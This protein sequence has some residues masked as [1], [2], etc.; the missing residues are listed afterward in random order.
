MSSELFVFERERESR[1]K[2]VWR[3]HNSREDVDKSRDVRD[4]LLL[5]SSGYLWRPRA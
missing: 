5:F 2:S 4:S 1:M 3:N